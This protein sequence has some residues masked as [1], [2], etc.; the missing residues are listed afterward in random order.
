MFK[1]ELL[2][3]HAKRGCFA[4]EGM[5]DDDMVMSRPGEWHHINSVGRTEVF[6]IF[7]VRCCSKPG[8]IGACE[9]GWKE[10][11]RI[12][13][14]QRA[15]LSAAAAGKQATIYGAQCAAEARARRNKAVRLNAT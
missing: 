2:N 4:R 9:R 15:K 14:G 5:F 13:V 7:A 12:M 6:G 11:K 1:K 3:F 8:G 10:V